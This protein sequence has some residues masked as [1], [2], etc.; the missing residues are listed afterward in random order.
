MR[1]IVVS[2]TGIYSHMFKDLFNDLISQEGNYFVN[3][4]LDESNTLRKFLFKILY[5]RRVNRLFKSNFEPLLKP[6]YS[7]VS[8]MNEC[9]GQ[10]KCVIFTNASLLKKYYNENSLKRIKKNFPNTKF[11][12]Y[13]VDSVFQPGSKEAVKLANHHIFDLVY[14]YSKEDARKYGYLYFPT[15]YS[16]LNFDNICST[17]EKGVYFCGSEKGRT[18]LLTDVAKRLKANNVNYQ[19]DINGNPDHSN[20]YFKVN[21]AD[22][23]VAYDKVLEKTLKYSCILDLIQN[24]LDGTMPG[25]SLRVLESFVY[26]RV[27][28]T[29]NPA[30]KRFRYYN[31]TYMHYISDAR[32][33]KSEWMTMLP[34][35]KYRGQL[36]P[37]NLAQD[38]ENRI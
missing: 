27:L 24:S 19:F 28:I 15:P 4:Y 37:L 9:N 11:V 20:E 32:D 22:K 16:K 25:L 30:I 29:N 33:I 5:D 10:P 31:P 7:L 38:I 2:E 35:N 6:K 18:G 34:E 36:S 3:S 17:P 23:Q 26:G 14:T 21:T 1:Y 12:L 8:V 13:F